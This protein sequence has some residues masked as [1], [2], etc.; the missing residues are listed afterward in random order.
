M[1]A[2][3]VGDMTWLADQAELRAD[4]RH[5]LPGASTALVVALPYESAPGPGPLRRARYAAG[6][7]YHKVLRGALA[8]VGRGIVDQR[9]QWQTR[10]C[11][12]S[13]PLN[14]RWLARKAGL[15]WHGRNALLIREGR[16]SYAFLGVLLCTGPLALKAGGQGADRCGRCRACVDRCPTQ[17]RCCRNAASAT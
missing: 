15:G 13:A 14:E 7:D 12:D 6:A 1:L 3:G 10:A 8:R 5:L 9:P 2:D 11:V 17:A 4:P 16:G